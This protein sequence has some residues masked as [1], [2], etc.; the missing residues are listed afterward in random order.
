[1][2]ISHFVLSSYDVMATRMTSGKEV[3]RI[4]EG[5]GE[6]IKVIATRERDQ[7]MDGKVVPVVE[8]RLC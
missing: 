4:S 6:Q 3:E 5:M 2:T 1:M 7:A 8:S